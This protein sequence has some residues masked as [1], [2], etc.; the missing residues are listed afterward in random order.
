MELR[1]F[2]AANMQEAMDLVRREL[3]EDVVILDSRTLREPA[4]PGL[5]PVERVEIWAQLP[6]GNTTAPAPTPT[7]V[8]TAQAD[9]PRGMP[10][11]AAALPVSE[12]T[13]ALEGQVHALKEQLLAVHTR[14][15]SLSDNMNWLGIG[16]LE[17]AGELAQ[18]IADSL[19]HKLP[20]T[21]GIHPTDEQH[22]VALVGPT[23]VGKTTTLAKLAWHFAVQENRKVG[24]IT[25]DTMR[26]GALEQVRLYCQHIEIPLEVAYDAADIT[27]ALERLAD[28]ALV[29]IDTP[30][31]S[32]RNADYLAELQ[33]LLLIAD[34]AEVHLV[35]S[36][37]A[38]TPVV[39]DILQHY[40]LLHPDQVI[41]TKLDEASS[42]IELF[43][44]IWSSGL[45]LSYFS[46][47]QM[48]AEDLLVVSAEVISRFLAKA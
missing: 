5:P 25:L 46:A 2:Y 4:G 33:E 34:P 21:G 31:G 39:R 36:A 18:C 32:Q 9:V 30:G 7:P 41:F 26:V 10:A 40:T 12:D 42:L 23:G 37:T 24:V 14:I 35:L 15:E 6:A 22:V 8:A 11:S 13:E 29:L 16:S 20:V 28:C 43:P 38:G 47:G 48:V 27:G 1:K 17:S 44:L 45:A 3:G 19:A